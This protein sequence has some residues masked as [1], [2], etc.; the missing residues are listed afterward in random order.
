MDGKNVLLLLALV[1]FL[2]AS[3]W[4]FRY[5]DPAQPRIHVGWLGLALYVAHLLFAH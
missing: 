1:C 2:L 3:F 5:P 4:G